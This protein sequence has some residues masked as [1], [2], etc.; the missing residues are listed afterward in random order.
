MEIYPEPIKTLIKYFS[1]LPGVGKR[2]GTRHVFHLLQED[3]IDLDD[4]AQK[5]SVLKEEITLCDRCF[6]VAKDE[7]ESNKNLCEICKDKE[8]DTGKIMI[9]EKISDIESLEEA[10]A[11]KGLYHVLGSTLP[12]KN[13]N[14]DKNAGSQ[15][16]EKLLKR[17][18]EKTDKGKVEVIIGLNPTKEGELSAQYLAKKIKSL[19]QADK[20]SLSR[21]G[22]GL[23]TGGEMA[24]ADKSTL[25]EAL[26]RRREV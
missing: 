17:I 8:R 15:S 11:F 5:L 24:Y 23:P 16:L 13:E 19:S 3:D 26:E 14:K 2:A 21:L 20:V 9:V 18:K 7:N 12:V 25:K 4:F 6:N 22:K 1:H 10:G